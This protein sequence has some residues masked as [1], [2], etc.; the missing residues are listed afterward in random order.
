MCDVFFSDR[1]ARRC[2]VKCFLDEFILVCFCDYMMYEYFVGYLMYEYFVG[3]F[4]NVM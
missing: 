4:I 2:C 3:Y 1:G